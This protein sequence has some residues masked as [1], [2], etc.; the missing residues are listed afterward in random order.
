MATIG[1]IKFR[2]THHAKEELATYN[3]PINKAYWLI[4]N[5]GPSKLNGKG[6]NKKYP[7]AKDIRYLENEFFIFT[8]RNVV[9]KYTHEPIKLVLSVY[10]TRLN[11]RP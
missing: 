10:D 8:I 11:Y 2:F 4:C 9:D 1:N 3:V 6:K 7:A 5:A